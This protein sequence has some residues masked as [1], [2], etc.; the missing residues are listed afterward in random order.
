MRPRQAPTPVKD[1]A[2]TEISWG[3]RAPP[4]CSQGAQNPSLC[5]PALLQL[6]LG[7]G[8]GHQAARGRV[9]TAP[10]ILYSDWLGPV[11]RSYDWL[12]ASH[13][14]LHL[15][16]GPGCSL[17]RGPWHPDT[18]TFSSKETPSALAGRPVVAMRGFWGSRRG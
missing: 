12:S 16:L 5:E 8:V 2:C 17:T 4:T 7:E 6:A 18:P 15:G 9:L 11:V 13:P 3:G 14:P 10:S 1:K